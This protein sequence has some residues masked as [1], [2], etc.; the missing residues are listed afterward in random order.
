MRDDSRLA[1]CCRT[2]F[3]IAHVTMVCEEGGCFLRAENSVLR[4]GG[5]AGYPLP[6]CFACLTVGILGARA[7]Q[8]RRC[9]S[10]A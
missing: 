1:A 2:G 9:V 8:G 6:T 4:A 7:G 10:V 3:S 5:L